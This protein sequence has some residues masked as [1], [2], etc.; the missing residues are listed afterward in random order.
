M[1]DVAFSNNTA[2]S[3]FGGGM[4]NEYGSSPNLTNVTFSGNS[5]YRGGGIYNHQDSNPQLM[6]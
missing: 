1:T 2:T 3:I 5:A 6:N 4:Y